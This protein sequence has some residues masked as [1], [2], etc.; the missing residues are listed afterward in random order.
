MN[1]L[2]D[3]LDEFVRDGFADDG[4]QAADSRYANAVAGF[5]AVAAVAH[6]RE[7][8]DK[9]VVAAVVGRSVFFDVG[10][11]YELVDLYYYECNNTSAYSSLTD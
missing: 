9:E 3:V 6:G 1:R 11:F 10:E 2:P 5:R 4:L 8:A 7:F